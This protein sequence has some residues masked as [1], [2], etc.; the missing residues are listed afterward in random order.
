MFCWLIAY[1]LG[2]LFI[3]IPA[4]QPN[5]KHIF[6]VLVSTF[7]F[8]PV[9]R[10]PF[11]FVQ[12]LASIFG[13]YFLAARIKGPNMPWIV[14]AF[15]MGHLTTNHAIRAMNETALE[16]FEITGP[17]MIMTMKLTMFAWN[18][19]DG[20]R[21]AEDLDKWQ[22]QKRVT[23]YPTL[24]E[25]LGFSFYFPSILCGP[26]IDYASYMSL[27]DGSLFKTASGKA[28]IPS[29]RTIPNGRK[30]VAYRKMLSGLLFLGIFA[31]LNPKFHYGIFLTPWFLTLNLFQRITLLQ[32]CGFVERC[33]YYASWTLSEG[34]IILTG[35]GFTGYDL[36][37]ESL[38]EGAA[39]VRFL[40]IEFPPNFKVVLD[41]W[42]ISTNVWLRE[43]VYK[44]VTPK[45][46][47]PGFKSSVLTSLTS[48]FWHGIA[49]GYY[50]TFVFGAFV[51][52]A[53]RLCRAGFRPLVLPPPGA[54]TTTAKRV[55]DIL[56]TV[57]TVLLV[58]Y[59]TMPFILLDLKDSLEGW[60]Q[61]GWYGFWMVGSALV[62]FFAGGSQYLHRLQ[63]QQEKSAESVGRIVDK[64]N[65]MSRTPGTPLV[66]PP[67]ENAAAELLLKEQN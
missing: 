8:I 29:K 33:K 63:K 65:E 61:F 50:L 15:V 3:R 21:P 60:R 24:L 30:R 49:F 4:S 13:T 25:F 59:A 10:V 58:N 54:P 64:K 12:L 36:S 18:V 1:P 5:F 67:L 17:Q 38:W 57:V 26:Y 56:G 20:R 2:S 9:L 52:T 66:V 7:F 44:R 51:T 16:T 28:K 31:V 47:K 41:S 14:F 34:A 62:F 53:A 27:I 6:N 11:G 48:A 45:G 37:G 32:L 46:K 35:Y 42:N 23:K 40:N 55:Y 43:C 22:I 19:F 39:N